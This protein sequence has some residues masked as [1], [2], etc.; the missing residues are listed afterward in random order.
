MLLC[1]YLS[2]IHVFAWAKNE[3]Y[4]LAGYRDNWEAY[5][6][7]IKNNSDENH[8]FLLEFVR[9]DSVEQMIEDAKTLAEMVL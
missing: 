5:I 2:N 8:D 4:P 7:I 9:G 1:P 3:R 6:N